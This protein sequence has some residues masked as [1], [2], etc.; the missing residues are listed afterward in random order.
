[1]NMKK[2]NIYILLT[3][4]IFLGMNVNV[5]SG[6]KTSKYPANIKADNPRLALELLAK[7]VD[8]K[9]EVEWNGMN[10]SPAY[11]G[12]TLTAKGYASSADKSLDAKRFIAENEELFGIKDPENE[13]SVVSDFTDKLSMTHIKY[14]Q[15]INGIKI[16]DG[17]LV[18]HIKSDGSIESVNGRYYPTE[19]INTTAKLSAS[20]AISIAKDRLRD[21]K[22]ENE[23]AEL[24][25]Y[26]KDN[27]LNLAY[28]VRLPSKWMPEMKVYVSAENGSI[29]KVD[30][31]IRYDGPQTGKGIDLKGNNQTLHT[32][33]S[34]GNYYLIDASLPMYHVVNDTMHGTI[35]TYDAQNDTAKSGFENVVYIQDPNKD[36]NFNDNAQLKA[37]VSAH[38]NARRA[39]EFYK[40]HFN[41]ESFN[42]TKATIMNVVHYKDRYNNA[43]W[44]GVCLVYGDGDGKAYSSIAEAFD[45][46][47]H[48]FT[49]AVTSSTADLVYEKQS[50]ALN[51]S[52]SDVFA[53]LADSTNWLIGEEVFTPGVPGDALRSMSDPHNGGTGPKD[54]SWQPAN[55]SEYVQ[56]QNDEPNDWG[57]VHINSGIPNKAFYNVATAISHWKAGAI[58]YRSLTVY[59]TK[60]SQ[61]NDLRTACLNSAKD[62]YGAGS[63]EYNA[64]DKGFK[65]VGIDGTTNNNETTELFYDDGV[66][67]TYVWEEAAGW[68]LAS[69][70]TPTAQNAQLTKIKIYL[71]GVADPQSQQVYSDLT[72]T[73]SFAVLKADGS[74]GLP[75][76]ILISSDPVS[77]GAGSTVCNTPNI[78]I[79]GDFYIAC[80]YNNNTYQP[81]IASDYNGNSMAYEYN[82]N[83]QQWYTLEEVY[84]S[85]YNVNLYIRAVLTSATS[86]TE[87]DNRIP[88]KFEISPNYP[89]PFNPTTSIRYSLPKGENVSV[90]VYDITG[91]E[92]AALVNNFQNPGT[93][94]ITWNGKNNSG[95]EVSSGV[96][97]YRIK[98]G[99]FIQTRKM[100]FLK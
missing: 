79:S 2:I 95:A 22:A 20:G 75:G 42:N 69:K 5:K 88:D 41:R 98:A 53:S 36:N 65:D 87:I 4:F 56:L 24:I 50:G 82:P 31:G 73:L 13:L 86:V 34:Q 66:P 33:L 94:V 28:E 7:R 55:M 30:D 32:Y 39:Y 52:I 25:I 78:P 37:A 23:K 51:E 44:N 92:I 17:Q 99:L 63:A 89:N 40:S 57:G 91:R 48:E 68:A 85:N 58:W 84:G 49:H 47:V 27:R 43:F 72:S 100:I 59:L 71:G 83:S 9:L 38:S 15:Q 35:E 45:V 67:D 97:L 11:I 64:V 19:D 80:V 70:F 16:F 96:Y 18:V 81:A 21:Y 8:H 77:I 29:L 26:N 3:A 76:K 60:N 10:S 54:Y 93:Y 74:N 62:I 12:G 90:V 46:T 6:V 61:F 14:Q 1:M